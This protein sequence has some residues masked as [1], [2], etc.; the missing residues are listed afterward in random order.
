MKN[1]Q[2]LKILSTRDSM[3]RAAKELSDAW[4]SSDNPTTRKNIS[5]AIAPLRDAVEKVE[6][7][8]G[9]SVHSDNIAK[10]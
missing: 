7:L 6:L 8:I 1:E 2:I 4:G 10:P 5:T 3:R 9:K